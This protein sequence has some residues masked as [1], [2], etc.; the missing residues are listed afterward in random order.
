MHPATTVSPKPS[1]DR[2][3]SARRQALAWGLIFLAAASASAGP[4]KTVAIPHQVS[5]DALRIAPDH[6]PEALRLFN[7]LPAE[8]TVGLKPH[9]R[10]LLA[11]VT[12][13]GLGLLREARD[14]L[15]MALAHEPTNS[16]LRKTLAKV[17]RQLEDANDPE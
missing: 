1:P 7:R 14:E 2:K 13:R 10:L 15:T 11:F 17:E 9:A 8:T 16:V 5:G 12:D 4:R 6:F 3:A